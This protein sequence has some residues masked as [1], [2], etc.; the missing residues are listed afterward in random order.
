MT[1][2]YFSILVRQ[3]IITFSYFR[4]VLAKLLQQFLHFITI[5][6]LIFWKALLPPSGKLYVVIIHG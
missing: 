5:P 2:G 4:K 3:L 1:G 6:F